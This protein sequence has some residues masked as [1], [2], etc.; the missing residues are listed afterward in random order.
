MFAFF[1]LCYAGECQNEREAVSCY[2]PDAVA[3]AHSSMLRWGARGHVAGNGMCIRSSLLHLKKRGVVAR[4]KRMAWVPHAFHA[5]VPHAPAIARLMH[6]SF[7]RGAAYFLCTHAMR[8]TVFYSD[9]CGCA[10]CGPCLP[11]AL[12]RGP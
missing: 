10:V 7:S 1:W 6:A 3:L 4:C 11:A 8:H 12:Q 5:I 9:G 2:T